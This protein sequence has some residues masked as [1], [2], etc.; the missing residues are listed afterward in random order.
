MYIKEGANLFSLMSNYFYFKVERQ[1]TIMALSML[2][3]GKKTMKDKLSNPEYHFLCQVFTLPVICKR[4]T[5]I[6]C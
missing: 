1:R 5:G 3:Q 2:N 6:V 4:R